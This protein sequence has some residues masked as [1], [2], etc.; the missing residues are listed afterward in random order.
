MD[1]GI[2]PTIRRLKKKGKFWLYVP[3]DQIGNDVT[4]CTQFF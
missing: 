2:V 3:K 1:L 4:T